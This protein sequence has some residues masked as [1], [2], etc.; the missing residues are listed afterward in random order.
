MASCKASNFF[1][2]YRVIEG[3]PDKPAGAL[4]GYFLTEEAAAMYY[5]GRGYVRRVRVPANQSINVLGAESVPVWRPARE[6]KGLPDVI[7]LPGPC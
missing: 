6:W 7:P 1:T 4:N 5:L 3:S 2:F